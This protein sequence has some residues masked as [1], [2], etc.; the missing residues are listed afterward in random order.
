MKLSLSAGYAISISSS[1]SRRRD[2]SAPL[3]LL[4]KLRAL[5]V[6]EPAPTLNMPLICCHRSGCIKP[7]SRSTS[8]YNQA[9]AMFQS[10]VHGVFRNLQHPG[11]SLHCSS[12]KISQLDHLA[13]ARI[14]LSQ[15]IQRFIKQK[16]IRRALVRNH[17]DFIEGN[18]LCSA[19]A[20]CVSVEPC[21]GRS[22]CG[23]SSA[24]RWQRSARDFSNGHVFDRRGERKLR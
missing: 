5:P 21:P 2:S 3:C 16:Q 24:Q 8:W 22:E 18:L 6:P 11:E 20:F 15:A 13:A 4:R 9:L 12:P 7:R 19:A 14:H 1:T 17:C 10:R 23:A